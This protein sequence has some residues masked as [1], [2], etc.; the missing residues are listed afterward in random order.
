[1]MLAEPTPH[2]VVAVGGHAD[3]ELLLQAYPQ[4]VFPWPHNGQPLLWFCP[5]PRFVLPPRDTVLSR[6]LK[7]RMRKDPFEIRADTAFTDVMR[8]CQR[9]YRPGQLGTWITDDMVEGFSALHERGLAHSIEAWHDGELVGGLY[10][11]SFGRV[12]FG[13]SMFATAADASKVA[14]AV[15]LAHLAQWEFWLVDCQVGTDHLARFGAMEIDRSVF[16]EL[17]EDNRAESTRLG[18]WTFTLTPREALEVLME[19]DVP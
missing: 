11:I 18:P 16:L 1:M 10:G 12:F 4:G 7:K 15:L 5:D 13:E 14:F 8:G 17:L 6:S 3:P 19:S 2:G 9:A